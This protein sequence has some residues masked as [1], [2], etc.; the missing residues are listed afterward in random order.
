VVVVCNFSLPKL[1]EEG[2]ISRAAFVPSPTPAQV[3]VV[4]ETF[5][6]LPIVNDAEA[7]PGKVGA[8]ST[9]YSRLRP[10]RTVRGTEGP[11]IM[12]AAFDMAKEVSCSGSVPMLVTCSFCE[13]LLP[14]GTVLKLNVAGETEMEE[15]W[16]VGAIWGAAYPVQP[17]STRERINNN[18]AKHTVRAAAIDGRDEITT[19]KPLRVQIGQVSEGRECRQPDRGTVLVQGFACFTLYHRTGF[20]VTDG[21][22]R[23]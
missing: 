8:N 18:P 10:G 7:L 3:T 2:L 1:I 15:L 14:T 21:R 6:L 23:G 22:R 20:P 17:T 4:V 5:A 11:V 9:E 12:K 19:L 16:G 13:A